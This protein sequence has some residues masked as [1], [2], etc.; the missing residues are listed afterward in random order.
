MGW[1]GW[2]EQETLNT[3]MPMIEAA[4]R[5][6]IKMLKAIHGPGETPKEMKG[7]T[8]SLSLFDAWFER[9]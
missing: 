5:G 9:E 7:R 4:Y 8:F 1:L 6:K 2:T 3:S